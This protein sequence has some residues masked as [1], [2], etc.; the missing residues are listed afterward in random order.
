MKAV[1]IDL[2]WPYGPDSG[3]AVDQMEVVVDLDDDTRWVSSFF[4]THRFNRGVKGFRGLGE[5]KPFRFGP[6]LVIVK[7]LDEATV[8]STVEALIETGDFEEAF[9][10]IGPTPRPEA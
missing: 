9:E 1:F 5:D 2:L 8:R 4:D 7:Q 3:R 10:K 6:R